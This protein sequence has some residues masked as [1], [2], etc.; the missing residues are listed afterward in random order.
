MLAVQKRWWGI[1]KQNKN[2]ET[3]DDKE[4]KLEKGKINL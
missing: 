3:G 2:K 4:T 1:I